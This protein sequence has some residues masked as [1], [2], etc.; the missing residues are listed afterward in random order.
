MQ[1]CGVFILLLSLYIV[2]IDRNAYHDPDPHLY[3]SA[4]LLLHFSISIY[5]Y[6]VTAAL[7]VLT[8]YLISSDGEKLL[9][10]L[11]VQI[12]EATDNLGSESIGYILEATRAL[13]INDEVAAV[14]A[15]RSL[16]SVVGRQTDGLDGV[17]DGIRD[18]LQG[19]LPSPTP[20]MKRFGRILTL[21]GAQNA[22]T[23]PSKFVPILRKLG[24]EPRVQRAS[25]EIIAKLGERLLSRSLRAAFGLAPPS[26]D[27]SNNTNK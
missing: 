8:D 20:S 6:D 22:R 18:E 15:F 21:L 26:F 9:D 7:D 2:R 16:Q 23:D 27:G 24:Q 17:N 19:V 1:T 14:K 25:S 3:T 13:A 12:V 11:S 4:S 10:E 5:R